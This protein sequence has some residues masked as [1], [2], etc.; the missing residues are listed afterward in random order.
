MMRRLLAGLS[1]TLLVAL[2]GCNHLAGVYDCDVRTYGC[3]G[4]CGGTCA[5]PTMYGCCPMQHPPIVS[6][7][8]VGTVPVTPA[9]ETAPLP[10]TVP[11][12][13]PAKVPDK[14]KTDKEKT[15]ELRFP[16]QGY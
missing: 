16:V 1:G 10:K 5:S 12:K 13:E 8:P 7:V 6:G 14:E 9:G 2:V 3:N 4:C 11:S 15:G